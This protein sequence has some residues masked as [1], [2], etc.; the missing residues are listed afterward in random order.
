MNDLNQQ[1]EELEEQER[2][3]DLLIG[4][5]TVDAQVRDL[6]DQRNFITNRLNELREELRKVQEEQKQRADQ[7]EEK[8]Y[9]EDIPFSVAGVEGMPPE[10]MKF[11]EEVVMAD[12]R[13]FFN[14]HAIEMEQ[15]EEESRKKDE[16]IET[17]RREKEEMQAIAIRRD[18]ET[19][20][21]VKN[22]TGEVYR[23]TAELADAESKRDAAVRE[24]EESFGY[25]ENAQKE[26]EK[27]VA[28]I[29]RL[30]SEIE[31]YQRAKMWG[32]RQAQSIIDVTPEENQ[33]IAAAAEAVKKLYARTED[34]GSIIKVTLPDGSF[35]LAKRS[36]VEKEWAPIDVPEVPDFQSQI[37]SAGVEPS[38]HGA[39]PTAVGTDV[40]NGHQV[41]AEIRNEEIKSTEE[42]LWQ[43]ENDVSR[44][45]EWLQ[46]LSGHVGYKEQEAA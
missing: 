25:L 3:I 35:T 44:M 14:E 5:E 27:M 21:L 43:L 33:S 32:E 7:I 11:T 38:E 36:E 41:T 39:D 37:E 6:T 8:V 46:G 45:H 1:I 42:R 24:K 10:V 19:H 9:A 31:D 18:I 13:K 20:E 40:G 23:L 29:N 17:L 30:K 2:N 15:L 22:Y 4:V 26:N 16:L 34:Y 12:R 28:E